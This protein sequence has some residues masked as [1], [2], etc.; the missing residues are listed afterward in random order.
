MLTRIL[1]EPQG[2]WT[3]LADGKTWTDQ[4]ILAEFRSLQSRF[5][6]VRLLRSEQWPVFSYS[7]WWVTV[8]A[9]TFTVPDDANRWCAAQGFDPDH[10][11]AKFI[12]TTD[13]AL[14]DSLNGGMQ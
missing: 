11:F 9:A 14:L 4:D 12:S 2:V 10:C 1:V 3:W 5:G 8:S 13:Y 7:G 6:D